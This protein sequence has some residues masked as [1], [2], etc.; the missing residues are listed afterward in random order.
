MDRILGWVEDDG[1]VYNYAD[2]LIKDLDDAGF[3]I[4]RKD[5]E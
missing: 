1:G 2:R 5:E 3:E 4:V